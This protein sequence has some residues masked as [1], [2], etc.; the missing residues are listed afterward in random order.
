MND[1]SSVQGSLAS[2]WNFKY[3]VFV[4]V[5]S[6]MALSSIIGTSSVVDR[7][8]WLDITSLEFRMGTSMVMLFEGFMMGLE[9]LV[10]DEVVTDEGCEA[11][12]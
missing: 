3:M 12:S 2:K 7:D 5:G 11:V 6:M 1:G 9:F 10:G 8:G 4:V